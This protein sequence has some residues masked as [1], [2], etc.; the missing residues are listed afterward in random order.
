MGKEEIYVRHEFQY[1]IVYH[2]SLI[3]ML[4]YKATVW[5]TNQIISISSRTRL[6]SIGFRL[7]ESFIKERTDFVRA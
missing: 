7:S 2:K 1:S 5:G 4:V 3:S 6:S